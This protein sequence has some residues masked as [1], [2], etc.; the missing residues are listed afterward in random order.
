MDEPADSMAAAP[1][2]VVAG[3]QHLASNA[4]W[5]KATARGRRPR[6]GAPHEQSAPLRRSPLP[7]Q[8][9]LFNGAPL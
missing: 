3:S 1:V 2:A 5:D 6:R 4:F 8:V 9:H 7:S